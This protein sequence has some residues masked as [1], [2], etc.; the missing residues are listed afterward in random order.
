MMNT[1]TL[2]NPSF[3]RPSSRPT[4]PAPPATH[5]DTSMGPPDRIPRPQHKLSLNAFRRASPAPSP[6][7]VM[8]P[9]TLV[10][11]G[12]YLESLS[13]KLS[14]AVSKALASPLAQT[15]SND[16]VSGKRPVPAGR[17]RALG[18]LIASELVA[19][20]NQSHV[21]RAMIRCL[22]RPLSVL[23][24]NLSAH[25]LP[26]ISAPAFLVPPAPT[27]QAPNPNPTQLHALALAGF[28]GELLETF[29]ELG[30]GMDADP[31]GDGLKAIRDGLVSVIGRVVNPLVGGIKTALTPLIA[32]LEAP[33]IING[34][35]HK[36]IA[37]PKITVVQHSSMVTLQTML[38]IYAKA[39]ARY[40][41]SNTLQATFASLLISLLWRSL[42]ALS[43]RPQQSVSRP[44]TPG[45]HAN[46]PPKRR[47][48]GHTTPPAGRFGIKLPPSRPP[49]PPSVHVPSTTAAD[50]RTL[51]DLLSLFPRPVAANKLAC[52][53]VDEAFDGLKALVALLEYI[54]NSDFAKGADSIEELQA[55]LEVLTADLP[56]LIAMPVVLRA[57]VTPVQPVSAMLGLS[58]D[59]YKKGCLPGFSRAEECAAV[60]GQRVLDALLAAGSS[61]LDAKVIIK[62]LE[63]EIALADD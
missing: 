39:L 60:V 1:I 47:D 45:P 25:L 5:T 7:P 14:E 9:I 21:H 57:H 17:G 24:T 41:V 55:E 13:L 49:S 23:L 37:G 38:P 52:E 44:N 51:Y 29:D 62:W 36:T 26:F 53:A 11:D 27:P 59:D 18:A 48:S 30:L 8:T 32:G 6:A 4:S 35:V 54:R 33:T 31:R 50:A 34:A 12:S 46:A 19:T 20:R 2:R 22:H 61:S 58:E 15:T 40:N 16:Q 43:H 42:V 56:T 3:F 63:G 10:Q 28:A